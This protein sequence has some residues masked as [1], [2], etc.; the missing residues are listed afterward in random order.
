MN[1][2]CSCDHCNGHIEFEPDQA[3]Q[4]IACPHCGLDTLLFLPSTPAEP[5]PSEQ[6]PIIDEA[7]LA[8]FERLSKGPISRQELRNQTVYS[9]E[10]TIVNWACGLATVG[11]AIILLML[12]SNVTQGNNEEATVIFF[13]SIGCLLA[14][15]I[16]WGIAHAIFDI[17]DCALR[18]SSEAGKE[19]RVS[20]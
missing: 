6:T 11:V 1:A 5:V 16:S 14:T 9:N 7:S 3:G 12:L 20:K 18:R 10:R 15:W 17:A 8:N 19:N 13:T 2:K 4:T